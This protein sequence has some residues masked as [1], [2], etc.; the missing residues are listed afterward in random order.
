MIIKPEANLLRDTVLIG[1]CSAI[2][3]TGP[4]INVLQVR[5]LRRTIA[6]SVVVKGGLHLNSGP[7]TSCLCLSFFI[8]EMDIIILTCMGCT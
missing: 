5:K 2:F 4:F 7:V 3:I 6:D 8:C 1:F